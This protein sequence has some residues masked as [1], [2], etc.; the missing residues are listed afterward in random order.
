MD[1]TSA[2]GVVVGPGGGILVVSQ[3]GTHW[4]L[5]KGHVEPGESL[6]EAARREIAEESG[7]TDLHLIGPLGSYVRFKIGKNGGEDP[8]E[9]KTLV[10]FLYHSSQEVLRPTDAHNP[11]AR[12]VPPRD[13]ADLLSHPKDRDFF[14]SVL[15]RVLPKT[16]EVPAMDISQLNP[17]AQVDTVL[18]DLIPDFLENRRNDIKKIRLWIGED[19][20]TD[21]AR[22]LHQMK[23]SGGMYGFQ[24][25]TDMS[26][27]MEELLKTAGTRALAPVLDR[28]DTYVNR[29]QVEY[30]DT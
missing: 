25:I 3:R 9:R 27:E 15:P 21:L 7:V 10:F 28:L 16:D 20:V 23:G 6:E 19:R 13:V 17:V 8:T 24:P 2:G 5:P 26:R 12:W 14:L 29:V 30:V 18:R 4:S 11:E 22:L 1:T